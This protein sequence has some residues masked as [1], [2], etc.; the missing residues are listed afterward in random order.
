M[1]AMLRHLAKGPQRGRTTVTA[2]LGGFKEG[3]AHRARSGEGIGERPECRRFD[4]S[5][6]E[7]RHRAHRR[8]PPLVGAGRECSGMVQPLPALRRRG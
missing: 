6:G 2:G 8:R 4:D 5:R 7:P 1:K 3:G